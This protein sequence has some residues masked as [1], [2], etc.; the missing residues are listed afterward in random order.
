MRKT[1]QKIA[2]DIGEMF[3]RNA[4]EMTPERILTLWQRK[5]KVK[6]SRHDG[7][8]FRR[9]YLIGRIRALV[10]MVGLGV[11]TRKEGELLR[12]E[13]M[14]RDFV[15]RD[16]NPKIGFI[17]IG[18]Y[19]YAD[20]LIEGK[21]ARILCRVLDVRGT[22]ALVSVSGSAVDLPLETLT[23]KNNLESHVMVGDVVRVAPFDGASGEIFR[24]DDDVAYIRFPECTRTYPTYKLRRIDADGTP[25]AT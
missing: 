24:V 17:E 23:V 8:S 1:Y 9:G 20:S 10:K 18:A 21:S 11:Y 3:V 22:S 13:A 19:V 15:E 25:T 5:N 2:E 16:I 14:L 4:R 12:I 7:Q 6:L